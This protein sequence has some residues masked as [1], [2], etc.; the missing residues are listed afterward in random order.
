M[1]STY[2]VD[3]SGSRHVVAAAT[4]ARDVLAAHAADVDAAGRFPAEAIEALARAGL[5][6]LFAPGQLG[7]GGQGPRVFAA[8]VEELARGCAST[9]MIYVMHVTG[10][11]AIAASVALDSRDAILREI[12]AGKH[13]TTLALSEGDPGVPLWAPLSALEPRDGGYVVSAHKSWVTSARRADSLVASARCAGASSAIDS[14]LYLMR[15]RA[16][17]VRA[18]GSFNGLGLR[19]IDAAPVDVEGYRLGERDLITPLGDGFKMTLEV[20]LPWLCL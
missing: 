14:A 12:A 1:A 17:D 9:A 16:A 5:S 13:L 8:V 19:G 6:G 4:L 2:G 3:G 7:G 11:Q 18:K 15:P 10:S 20:L